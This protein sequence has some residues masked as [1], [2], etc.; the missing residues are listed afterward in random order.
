MLWIDDKLRTMVT[1]SLKKDSTRNPDCFES[2]QSRLIKL[3][4][5][6]YGAFFQQEKKSTENQTTN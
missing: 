3:S 4:K 2:F 6:N 1:T 5:P